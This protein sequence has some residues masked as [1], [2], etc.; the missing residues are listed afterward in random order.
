MFVGKGDTAGEFML[1][2]VIGV[3]AQA[4]FVPPTY[5]ASAPKLTAVFRRGSQ[6]GQVLRADVPRV[7]WWGAC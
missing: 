7:P 1:V 5:T 6:Q 3:F 2:E 4:K